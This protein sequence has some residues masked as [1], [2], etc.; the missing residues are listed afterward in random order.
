[1]PMAIKGSKIYLTT[2]IQCRCQY[3]QTQLAQL[4]LL[5]LE[6][7]RQLLIISAIIERVRSRWGLPVIRQGRHRRHRF[8]AWLTRADLEE[9][10]QYTT[11]MPRLQ[12]DDSMAYLIFIWMPTELN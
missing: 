11:S 9:E 12:L 4:Q 2:Q 8:R 7:E 6:M 1:M 10:G 5:L 3:G